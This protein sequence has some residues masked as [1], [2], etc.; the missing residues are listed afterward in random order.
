MDSINQQQP[1]KNRENLQGME[2]AHKLKELGEKAKTCFFCTHITTGK[3][4]AVRPMA[5]QHI[6]DDGTCWF[7]SATDSEK[8]IDITED[9]AVQLLFQ[10]S[11]H[12]DFL[13]FYGHAT[14]SQDKA[15]IA[16]L[17]EPVFKT[18]FTEGQDDPRISVIRVVPE[19]GYYWDTKHG[20]VV[21][22]AKQ[23]AGA[24][25]GKTLDD[26]IEGTLKL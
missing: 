23:V 8:N 3:Q 22:F 24:M 9:P 6:D 21:A 26:S 19:K 2:A 1:E 10:G 5:V 18:W 15:K 4:F 7:L 12:S 20:Q 14:I 16:E 25:M 13:S 17:W 11:T